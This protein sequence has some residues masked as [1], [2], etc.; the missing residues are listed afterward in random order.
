MTK[1]RKRRVI[2]CSGLL[3]IKDQQDLIDEI[4]DTMRAIKE[5]TQT[6]DS[7]LTEDEENVKIQFPSTDYFEEMN[8]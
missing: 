5:A 6:A 2:D 7:L 4:Q 1:L 3:P 8:F